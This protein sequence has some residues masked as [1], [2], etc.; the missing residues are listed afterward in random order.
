MV[1]SVVSR[2]RGFCHAVSRIFRHFSGRE[3]FDPC[4]FP[5]S[6]P[7][8]AFDLKSSLLWTWHFGRIGRQLLRGVE[9]RV[10]EAAGGQRGTTRPDAD[11]RS[12]P[13]SAQERRVEALSAAC[14]EFQCHMDAF[15]RTKF[16]RSP[17]GDYF[18]RIPLFRAH[19]RLQA[20]L[21]ESLRR[22]GGGI[23]EDED[24]FQRAA[25]RAIVAN[26]LGPQD[27]FGF[28]ETGLAY[29]ERCA[30]A[31]AE[32]KFRT[33]I[34]AVQ[35]GST[36]SRI[37]VR[38]ED[39]PDGETWVNAK[40][41]PATSGKPESWSIPLHLKNIFGLL[42]F[43]KNPAVRLDCFA[44]FSRLIERSGVD[45]VVLDLVEARLKLAK[46]LGFDSHVDLQS[47]SYS[48]DTA[49]KRGAFLNDV[50][51]CMG[52][53][54]QDFVESCRKRQQ[55][56]LGLPASVVG[57]LKQIP[58]L[59]SDGA[60][61]EW[62]EGQAG[63]EFGRSGVLQKG[64][65]PVESTLDEI[66]VWIGRIFD[67][68]IVCVDKGQ[69]ADFTVYQLFEAGN[70]KS[71]SRSSG[72]ETLGYVY[73][74]RYQNSG[75]SSPQDFIRSL[76]PMSWQGPP[77]KANPSAGLICPGHVVL[78][79]GL[80]R[81]YP[82]LDQNDV[83]NVFHE[84]GHAL[85]FLC[86]RAEALPP[87]A[88]RSAGR[89][90]A[91][92]AAADELPLTRRSLQ[93]SLPFDVA[94]F[95]STF[96]EL[97]ARQPKILESLTEP[98]LLSASI[99]EQ[100][101][102]ERKGCYDMAK[103]IEMLQLHQALF[104]DITL[105]DV[106]AVRRRGAAGGGGAGKAFRHFL[107]RRWIQASA[108]LTDVDRELLLKV[109]DQGGTA[110]SVELFL[111]SVREST[112]RRGSDAA[113]VESFLKRAVETL[114]KA[115]PFADVRLLML[116]FKLGEPNFPDLFP[117]LL[118]HLNAGLMLVAG[119][120]RKSPGA[121]VDRAGVPL[122]EEF[123]R[124]D[125]SDLIGPKT[126]ELKHIGTIQKLLSLPLSLVQGRHPMPAPSMQNV[127]RYFEALA[128]GRI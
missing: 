128:A 49:A 17:M 14:A 30:V 52:P 73:V 45:A 36:R 42:R 106:A 75:W 44:Q 48:V 76:L 13:G 119:G 123:L 117:Y 60:Y 83:Y 109:I 78:Q 101:R 66:L 99:R 93:C 71:S 40:R 55:K 31:H 118:C 81:F 67:V 11:S 90:P 25:A 105:E 41:V 98:H 62:Q 38:A 28:G 107:R 23:V 120:P 59:L 8:S 53:F 32:R 33:A 4:A 113:Q 100:L 124:R 26:G 34:G 91:P 12:E 6:R 43:C 20:S 86:V 47:A 92:P 77:Q 7:V 68:K 127:K 103:R 104:A 51:A 5:T 39:L 74:R 115:H 37:T 111:E 121:S 79:L 96:C 85:H 97:V 15:D 69:G 61:H 24:G 87:V 80:D 3:A 57:L 110:A 102:R 63:D 18:A 35:K 89:G 64:V 95:P 84:V 72:D 108:M 50:D 54:R 88:E 94:E 114:T 19:R 1:S 29:T 21:L 70:E 16:M 58:V 116:F 9:A 126:A 56:E 125:F 122:K 46:A 65:F 10:V 22:D 2:G 112:K 27:L 82:H